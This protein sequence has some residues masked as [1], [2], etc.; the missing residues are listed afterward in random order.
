M[1]SISV[2]LL[3]DPLRQVC[4]YTNFHAKI[5]YHFHEHLC[6]GIFFP[7]KIT[8]KQIWP[9]RKNE[10]VKPKSLILIVLVSIGS[11]GEDLLRFLQNMGNASILIILFG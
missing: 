2:L 8:R 11:E 3:G 4:I 9:C 5:F 7:N 10:K 1:M 6:A